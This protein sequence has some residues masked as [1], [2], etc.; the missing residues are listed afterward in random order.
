MEKIKEIFA[1][2]L[3][4]YRKTLG[5]TQLDLAE[6]LHYSDKAISKWERGES[7]PDVVTLKEISKIFNITVDQLI[8]KHAYNK[9]VPEVHVI[10]AKKQTIFNLK[11]ALL[12]GSAIL[13]IAIIVFVVLTLIYPQKDYIWLVFIYSIP[14]ICISFLLFAIFSKKNKLIILFAE[15]LA[16]SISLVSFFSLSIAK[17]W[18]FFIIPIPVFFILY[19]S[20]SLKNNKQTQE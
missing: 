14:L 20:L 16:F 6:K 10:E 17:T 7:L 19:F 13:F 11:L 4:H 15:L 2:N 9:N 18:L 5:L 12:S 1:E 3:I 8:S